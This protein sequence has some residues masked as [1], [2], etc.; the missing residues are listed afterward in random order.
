M[1]LLKNDIKVT[2]RAENTLLTIYNRIDSS[3]ANQRTALVI[4][5]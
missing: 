3:V 2:L 4:E 5:C 1:F